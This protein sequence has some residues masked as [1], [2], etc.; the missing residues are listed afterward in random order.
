M[1]ADDRHERRHLIPIRERDDPAQ[2]RY[3]RTIEDKFVQQL[4]DV[5]LR[6]V[7]RLTAGAHGRGAVLHRQAQ[8]IAGGIEVEGEQRRPRHF[9]VP[10]AVGRLACECTLVGRHGL[11]IATLRFGE[12]SPEKMGARR[13]L[14]VGAQRIQQLL[15]CIEFTEVVRSAATSAHSDSCVASVPIAEARSAAARWS[16]SARRA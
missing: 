14:L 13:F 10:A 3:C 2:F 4:A 12:L 8:V 9:A 15:G 1:I 7:E 6:R 16:P 11:R 5:M